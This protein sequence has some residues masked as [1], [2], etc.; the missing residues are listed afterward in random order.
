MPLTKPT[1]GRALLALNLLLAAA[2]PANAAD[3]AAAPAPADAASAETLMNTL[4]TLIQTLVDQGVLNAGKAQQM[5]RQAGID[6]AVLGGAARPPVSPVSPAAPGAPG[7][8]ALPALG[9]AGAAVAPEAPVVRV[10]YVPQLL[11]DELRE[12]L[13]QEVLAKA[14]EEHWAE[15]G[16]LPAWIHRMHWYGDVRFRVEREDYADDNATPQEIDT[17]YQLPLGTTL[18]TEQSRNR[19]RLRARLGLDAALDENFSANILLVT[20]T[21]TSTSAASPV[22]LNADQGQFGRPISVGMSVAYLQWAPR[23]DVHVTGGR[24]TNPY[25][26]SDVPFLA[27][28][29]IWWSDLAFDGLLASYTPHMGE[30]WSAHLTGG[31]HPLQTNQLGPYNIAPQQWLYAGQ[32]GVTYTQ[33]DRSTFSLGTSLFSFVGMQGVLNP[34]NPP[35]STLES[36]SAPLYRQRGNTMFDLNWYSNPGTP[37]WGYA[38]QFRE[39]EVDANFEL[40][41]FDPLRIGVDLDYVR[42]LGFNAGEIR[43][44][45]GGA[46]AGLPLDNAGENGVERPKVNAYR[47]G[48]L[49]GRHSVTRLGDWQAFGGYRYLER[50]AVVDAFTSPDYHLGGTDQKGVYLGMNLGLGS[51][52]SMI[53]RYS[54]M[55]AIDAAPNF[56]I[57]QWFLD[58]LGRF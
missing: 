55:R 2:V 26:S 8:A 28:D 29:L 9:Q 16:T 41:R 43:Q 50:D 33:Q 13:K 30:D 31:A 35:G 45:I 58:F 34:A 10:P 32:A 19:P 25:L 6:P 5:L 51:N 21:G 57:N 11:K 20:T 24:V 27:S 23:A 17:Y 12:Q 15:P 14:H 22:S 49:V 37:L 36:N 47:L 56:E 52:S 40:A 3:A 7:T 53:L 44:H 18:T 4:V 48:W 42:N 1:I 46:A 54:A 39:L 38:S